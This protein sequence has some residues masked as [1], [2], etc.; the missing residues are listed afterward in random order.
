MPDVRRA[1][2]MDAKQ[3]GD[4]VFAVGETR[5]EMG[6]SEYYAMHGAVG[7]R[8]PRVDTQRARALYDVL[9]DAM[10]RGLVNACHDC[11]DGGFAVAAAEMAFAGGLGMR[12]DLRAMPCAADVTR[13]DTLLFSETASRFVVTVPAV[14][15]EAFRDAMQASLCG[16]IGV[17]HDGP[18]FTVTGLRGR[19]L[20]SPAGLTR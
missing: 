14:Y 11:S 18:E 12:L 1:V 8:V 6:G 3:A 13:D 5:N 17:V 2:T 4:L 16:E 7:N 20:S 19:G 9:A 15:R 10:Q